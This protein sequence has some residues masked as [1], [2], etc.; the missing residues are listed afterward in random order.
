MK[1]EI[2]NN[3]IE[4]IVDMLVKKNQDYGNA[5]FDL[6]DEYGDIV[7]IIHLKEKLYRLTSL[8]TQENKN[9][10]SKEDSIKDIIGY[11]I[12]YLLYKQNSKK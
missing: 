4:P 2:L 9:F 1:E 6:L 10:E 5:F 12:L 8:T 3:I 7:F 11:C